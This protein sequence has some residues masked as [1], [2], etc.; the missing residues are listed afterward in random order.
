[1]AVVL[2]RQVADC[3]CPTGGT[4]HRVTETLSGIHLFQKQHQYG[5]YYQQIERLTRRKDWNSSVAIVGQ[6]TVNDGVSASVTGTTN[7][8]T[9]AWDNELADN[10]CSKHKERT[11]FS[12]RYFAAE[13]GSRGQEASVGSKVSHKSSEIQVYYR[14]IAWVTC[15]QKTSAIKEA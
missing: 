3:F 11:D 9:S 8:R 7:T 15:N 12:G 4:E 6:C 10:A 14:P 2:A 5:H 1:M 13:N